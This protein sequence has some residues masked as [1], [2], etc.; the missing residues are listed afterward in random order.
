M[1]FLKPK[2]AF[3]LYAVLLLIT[4]LIYSRFNFGGNHWD[5]IFYF[6]KSIE[7]LG[8]K[9]RAGTRLEYPV[10]AMVPLL[11]P[12][13]FSSAQSDIGIYRMLFMF[14][15]VMWL[16]VLTYI[17]YRELIYF[18]YRSV[19]LRLVIFAAITIPC[20][21]IF[22][23]MDIFPALMTLI[24]FVTFLHHRYRWAGVFLALSVATK[25]YAVV[26]IPVFGMILLVWWNWKGL[27]KFVVG[28]ALPFVSIVLLW[29]VIYGRPLEDLVAFIGPHQD[30]GI[31]V[32]SV[33]A[34]GLYAVR[35]F[36]DLPLKV[37]YIYGADHLVFFGSR[38]I[39]EGLT[40][41][42]IL[43][44]S[45]LILRVG[46]AFRRLPEDF[47]RDRVATLA[48]FTLASVFLFIVS[49]K[50]FS[51][52]YLVW[53][54]PFLCFLRMPLMIGFLFLFTL[55]SGLFPFFYHQIQILEPVTIGILIL[56][57]VLCCSIVVMLCIPARYWGKND[58][59]VLP[60]L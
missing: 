19:L 32:E 39:L 57:N 41:V 55:S 10:L 51:P 46:Y 56:R 47:N 3:A 13:V 48:A 60:S 53:L 7:F 14:E 6:E 44:V 23:R 4:V 8:M 40:I 38:G 31:Q 1:G 35:F 26:L 21:V 25:L 37:K 17:V 27:L 52:Q 20:Q 18:G 45:I 5:I 36:I 34:T 12:H 30:R 50:V 9:E 16:L 11:I 43:L 22:F 33:V 24:A 59:W 42:Y 54:I 58:R 28:L 2:V 15:N 29:G 49:N